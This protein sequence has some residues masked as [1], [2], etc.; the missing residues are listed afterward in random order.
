M[1]LYHEFFGKNCEIDREISDYSDLEN[2]L[3]DK[4]WNVSY[5]LFLNQVHGD[6]TIV[7]DAA[8]KVYGK[9]LIGK[10]ELPQADAI[11]TNL[12]NVAI[13][14]I[15]ADCAPILLF[16]EEKKIIGAA[17]AGWRGARYGIIDSVID[18]MKNLGA[19]NITAIIGPMIHQ[20]SYEVS[21][22][23]LTEFLE[24]SQENESFFVAGKTDKYY[25][26]LPSYVEKKLR[27]NSVKKI[28]SSKIDTYLDEKFHSF[29]KLTHLGQKNCG[30][31]V[32]IIM[33]G[34][35]K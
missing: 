34:Q 16:D 11:V 25:F 23:F 19:T 31:N 9:G 28:T 22:E 6:K 17:H 4:G 27:E 10:S 14:V 26:D 1:F 13:A 5:I 18:E 30:R 33:M 7:I 2:Q 29:R 12:S 3:S 15:T 20:K 35:G 32:S 24:E 21:A 8:E